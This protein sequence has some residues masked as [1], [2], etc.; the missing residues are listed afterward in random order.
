MRLGIFGGTFDPIHYGHLIAAETCRET[1]RLDLVRFIP[2]ASPPHKPG[3]KITDGHA[4]ADML[5]LAISG[6]PEFVVDRRELQR[7]GPSFTVDTLTELHEENPQAELFFLMG[8]DSLRDLL[9]WRNPERIAQLA[10]LAVCNRPGVAAVSPEQI[11]EWV[12]PEI[13]R[14]VLSV[15][16]P[17]T[18]LSATELRQRVAAGHNLRFRTPRAVE[19]FIAHNWLYR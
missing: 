5:K 1:L 14:R 11:L 16:I 2:A 8:A 19:A 3:V 13:A 10:T 17:G 18:D 9:T 6:Y 4:R 7:T 12:G 15:A